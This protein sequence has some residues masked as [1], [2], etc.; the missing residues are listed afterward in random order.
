MADRDEDRINMVNISISLMLVVTAVFVMR[1]H[2]ENAALRNA[3]PGAGSRRT[4]SCG[5]PRRI[6]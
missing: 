4:P 2:I 5:R 1:E 3:A 6:R